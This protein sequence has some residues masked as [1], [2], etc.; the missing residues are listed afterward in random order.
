MSYDHTSRQDMLLLG[1]KVAA[2]AGRASDDVAAILAARI[3]DDGLMRM[4]RVMHWV[5]NIKARFNGL[6]PYVYWNTSFRAQP[7]LARELLEQ[8]GEH[9]AHGKDLTDPKSAGGLNADELEKML[10]ILGP[11]AWREP[12]DAAAR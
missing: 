11:V 6:R 1:R 12:A 9:I 7:R 2:F 10:D 8:T 4:P 5:V 3:V